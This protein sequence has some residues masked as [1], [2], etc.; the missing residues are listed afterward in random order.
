MKTS[1]RNFIKL[2]LVS[3]AGSTLGCETLAKYANWSGNKYDVSKLNDEQKRAYELYQKIDME[4]LTPTQRDYITEY[5]QALKE[6]DTLSEKELRE[7]QEFL[8]YFPFV[9]NDP[10]KLSDKEKIFVMERSNEIA[11]EIGL[12]DFSN[13]SHFNN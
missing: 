7:T 2:G 13:K 4:N 6:L 3:L 5:N 11:Q 1:R 9:E 12:I 10:R 8:K